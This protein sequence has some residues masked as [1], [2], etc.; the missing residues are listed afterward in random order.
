MGTHHADAHRLLVDLA[1]DLDAAPSGC[2]LI[3]PVSWY[4][5]P[6]SVFRS[7]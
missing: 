5:S 1:L 7:Q 2:V 6:L 3:E 4:S